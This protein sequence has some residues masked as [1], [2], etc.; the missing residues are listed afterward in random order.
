MALK[1]VRKIAGLLATLLALPFLIAPAFA[2][3]ADS[4]A[5]AYWYYVCTRAAEVSGGKLDIRTN[6]HDDGTFQQ[7][8]IDW[9]GPT[10]TEYGVATMWLYWRHYAGVRDLE[11][12][13]VHI[14]INAQKNIPRFTQWFMGGREGRS[15]LSA[16]VDSAYP[17]AKDSQTAQLNYGDLKQ[18]MSQSPRHHWVLRSYPNK[19]GDWKMLASGYFERVFFQ[20]IEQKIVEIHAEL[21]ALGS[22]YVSACKRTPYYEDPDGQI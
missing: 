22:N 17:S 3:T 12:G 19:S 11:N 10:N 4:E 7:E 6:L 14:A 16:D 5:P 18:Y 13:T 20:S 8:E 21:T 15:G 9:R 2:Q 1:L